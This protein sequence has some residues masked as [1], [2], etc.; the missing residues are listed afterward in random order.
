MSITKPNSKN[1]IN[2]STCI[3]ID[4]HTKIKQIAEKE[5]RSMGSVIERLVKPQL[6]KEGIL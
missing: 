5:D 1:R 6:E 2:F 3:D 4:L